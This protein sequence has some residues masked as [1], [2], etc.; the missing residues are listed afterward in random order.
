MTINNKIFRINKIEK[1]DEGIKY[2]LNFWKK[3][4]NKN[5]LYIPLIKKNKFKLSN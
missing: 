1:E 5:S 3:Q 2:E 4:K